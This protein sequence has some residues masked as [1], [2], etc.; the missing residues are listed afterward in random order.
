MFSIVNRGFTLLFIVA[1]LLQLNDPD[2]HVWVP[3][4]AI[5]ASWTW[6]FSS[7][8]QV[9]AFPAVVYVALCAG[10]AAYLASTLLRGPF[11]QEVL[12]ESL[13]LLICCAW[14]LALLTRSRAN[15]A[16][17]ATSAA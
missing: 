8:R 7:R 6:I 13:G 2:P 3:V 12:W 17:S 4:Y 5:A 11:V 1:A 10:A 15:R 16:V 14:T 9:P